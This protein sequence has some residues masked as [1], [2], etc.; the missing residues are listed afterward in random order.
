[1]A[2][3]VVLPKGSAAASL[4][5]EHSVMRDRADDHRHIPLVFKSAADRSYG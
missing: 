3:L 5:I 4:V 1:V 2:E